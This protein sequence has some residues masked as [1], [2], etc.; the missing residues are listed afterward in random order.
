MNAFEEI[1]SLNNKIID[2]CS[3]TIIFSNK[4]EIVASTLSQI[5]DSISLFQ[6][7]VE[8]KKENL[9]KLKTHLC[10]LF[11][12]IN[13]LTQE[14]FLWTYIQKGKPIQ[15]VI[16]DININMNRIDVELQLIGFDTS[17][18]LPQDN[19][20]SD[21]NSIDEH[22]TYSIQLLK[23]MQREVQ[24]HL[25]QDHESPT[26]STDNSNESNLD[27]LKKFPQF[28]LKK[29]DF[30]ILSKQLT[31]KNEI[32]DYYEGEM[33]KTKEKVTILKMKDNSL[34]KRLL[35]VLTVIKHPY[36]ESFKGA[37]INKN[38]KIKLITNR[39][40]DRLSNLLYLSHDEDPLE[41]GDRAILAFK[42]A[43]AMS[44]L[45]SRSIIHR[46]LNSSNIY[47]S[48]TIGENSEIKPLVVGFRNSRLIPNES[49]SFM[50]SLNLDKKVPVSYFR[51]P[52]LESGPYDEKVDVFAFAGILYELIEGH[53]PFRDRLK[54]EVMKMLD[55][56][57]RP[58]FTKK[59]PD[60]LK[61]L[62]EC[63]WKQDPKERYTFDQVINEMINKRIIFPDDEKRSDCI[64]KFYEKKKVKNDKKNNCIASFELIKKYIGKAFQYRF[65][66]LRIRSV[67]NTYQFYL[68]T[69]KFAKKEDL[70]DDDILNDEE[71]L[72]ADDDDEKE[73]NEEDQ[74]KFESLNNNLYDLQ[75]IIYNLNHD[76]YVSV[77]ECVLKSKLAA[78]KKSLKRKSA[79][80]KKVAVPE[81]NIVKVTDELTSVMD[82]IYN[83]M[84]L[85]GFKNIE[86]YKEV[87]DDLIYDYRELEIYFKEFCYESRK[88]KKIVYLM[89]DQINQIELFKT[90][91]NLNA[92]LSNE[93][94][95]N[96][97]KDLFS[98][99]KQYEVSRD[100]FVMFR[101]DDSPSGA[102]AQVH[103]GYMKKK[104]KNDD[105]D[106]DNVVAIKELTN[107]A[108]QGELTLA[109][110]RMEI[111]SLVMLK[112]K[113]IAKFIGYSLSDDDNSVWFI[114]KF[115]K[116]GDLFDHIHKIENQNDEIFTPTVRTK[117]AFKISEAMAYVHSKGR[118]H[119]D[120]KPDNIMFDGYDP[121][122]IDFGY[123]GPDNIALSNDMQ[124]GMPN[125]MAPEVILSEEDD[126]NSEKVDQQLLKKESSSG[127]LDSFEAQSFDGPKYDSK[128][129]VFSFGIILWEMY[130]GKIPFSQFRNRADVMKEIKSGGRLPFDKP[131][132]KML[133][134]LIKECWCHDPSKRPSFK[135]IVARMMRETIMFPGSDEVEIRQF[136]ENESKIIS[137]AMIKVERAIA[138]EQ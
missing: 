4:C 136:Y 83:S 125:Y 92:D 74:K 23:S 88:T 22:L 58:E 39:Q 62:I 102:T 41:K 117:V 31:D 112:H 89:N 69:P 13:S 25:K 109:C 1:S 126:K 131:I 50:T 68:K 55:K 128:S 2:A 15:Q 34:F 101:K 17:F 78:K 47:I 100:D 35:S 124:L 104:K 6:Q 99:F 44:Y 67:L 48:R 123:S 9:K 103:Q 120:L 16:S 37:Y 53:A 122:I 51:A 135:D 119:H 134:D 85:L 21:Y 42:I 3:K 114:S 106:D 87:S 19:L 54:H 70:N 129:D 60:E 71:L 65:E 52:E 130:S 80:E 14:T 86:K 95:H 66:L 18:K 20:Y 27:E 75:T 57:Q 5:N 116:D 84:L 72:N 8:V 110:L 90:E 93:A 108:S 77:V 82:K 56:C 76:E 26:E 64:E 30:Q 12:I 121:K 45:H 61:N 40:G 91:R 111:G 32:F 94:F 29:T 137:N 49:T 73:L 138:F 7:T 79:P 33:A 127:D 38:S 133:E 118:L 10:N 96:R 115:Y 28:N 11:K 98:P 43:Q 46:N 63:C 97:L 132:P 105:N 81:L 107:Y 59:V 36:V 113:Y 24:D